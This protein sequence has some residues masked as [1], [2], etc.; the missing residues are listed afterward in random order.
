M[1]H[2]LDQCIYVDLDYTG[3]N[4]KCIKE[5]STAK[6]QELCKKTVECAK[7]SYITDKYNG[8]HGVAA[9]GNCCLKPDIP[10]GLTKQPGVISGPKI[11]P[12]ERRNINQYL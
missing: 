3:R 11:C 9:R 8:E 1:P 5:P 6:C 2:F 4:L 10:S 7:F 12:G